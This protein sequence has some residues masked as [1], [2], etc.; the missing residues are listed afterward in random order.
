[1]LRNDCK[2]GNERPDRLVILPWYVLSASATG[3]LMAISAVTS[4]P[5]K[6]TVARATGDQI[7]TSAN[8]IGGLDPAHARV[9]EGD[10]PKSHL[11]STAKRPISAKPH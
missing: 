3:V 10:S 1:M 8:R 4:L 6:C 2:G 5:T 7:K 11:Y 9:S